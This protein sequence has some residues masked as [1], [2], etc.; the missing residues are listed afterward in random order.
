MKILHKFY[1]GL[2]SAW[3]MFC[4]KVCAHAIVAGVPAK[5][6]K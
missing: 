1:I 2:V 5:R 6:I 3:N 4:A